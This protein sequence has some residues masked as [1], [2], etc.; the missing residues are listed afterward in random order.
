M[1]NVLRHGHSEL[2]WLWRRW[3]YWLNTVDRCNQDSV[4]LDHLFLKLIEFNQLA[5]DG[6]LVVS[7]ALTS[8]GQQEDSSE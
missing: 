3:G 6:E 1:K 8:F 2:G 5:F 4:L 7:V